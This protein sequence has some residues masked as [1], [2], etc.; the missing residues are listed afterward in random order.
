MYINTW[1]GEPIPSQWN[2]RLG[3]QWLNGKIKTNHMQTNFD[4]LQIYYI[5]VQSIIIAF[6]LDLSVLSVLTSCN[7]I[8]IFNPGTKGSDSILC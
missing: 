2:R 3:I 8:I 7:A 4:Y 5:F 6:I 1:A